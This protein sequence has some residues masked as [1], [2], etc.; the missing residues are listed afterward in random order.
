MKPYFNA[1]T[2]AAC[3]IGMMTLTG[4]HAIAQTDNSFP[5]QSIT[6]TVPFPPGGGTDIS[7]RVLAHKMSEFAGV[8]VLVDN[9]P[10][11]AGQIATDSLVRAKPDGYSLLFAN[12]GIMA[13]NP[14]LYTLKNDPAES[15]EPISM[16]S[17]LPFVLVVSENVEARNIA[18]LVEQ[19]K[20]Q[21]GTLTYA[22]SGTGGA[23]HLAAEMFQQATQTEFLHIPYKGGGQ[24]LA[25]LIAGRVDMLF[26]SI[27]ET[28][29]HIKAGKLRALAVT[30]QQRSE[31]I[32]EVP[33]LEESGVQGA[34]VNSWTAVLAPKGI[35]PV[36]RD[37]LAQL[38]DQVAKDPEVQKKLLNQGAVA[39]STTP[40][41]LAQVASRDRTR[42]GELI[43]SRNLSVPQ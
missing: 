19:A 8:T 33:T 12:S 3:L 10:G 30:G 6:L 43:R 32:P 38:I 34:N 11:A 7:A 5:A 14:W 9:K 36:H 37:R 1:L 25:D 26:A 2:R 24:A 29:P 39:H 41:Q 20:K 22:S 4:G 35:D 42:F 21:A 31:A 23:P 13:I 17:D 27:L 40:E 28:L 18:E 16:F 15:F